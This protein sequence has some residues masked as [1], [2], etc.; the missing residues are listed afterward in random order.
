ME[1]FKKVLQTIKE[2]SLLQK[3]D[4]LLLG[5]SGGPDSVFLLHLL[6]QLRSQ[7]QLKIIVLHINHQLR[8]RASLRDEDFVK[9][10]ASDLNLPFL[11]KRIDVL[12]YQKKNKLSLEEAGRNLRH[13]VFAEVCRTQKIKKVVL[14]HTASDQVETILM[15][16]CRGTS[17]KGLSGMAY[18]Q[19]FKI[20]EGDKI[21]EFYVIRPLLDCF[22]E[23]ILADLKNRG[24]EYRIDQSN[25]HLNFTRNFFRHRIIP[26]FEKINP[27]FKTNLLR[28]AKEVALLKEVVKKELTRLICNAARYIEGRV[29]LNL[30]KWQKLN[31]FYRHE[32]I[33]FLIAKFFSTKD[34]SRVHLEEVVSLLEKGKVGR[35]KILPNNLAVYKDYDKIIISPLAL[36][37]RGP[38]KPS[39]LRIPGLTPIPELKASFRTKVVK[40]P[41]HTTTY[42][43]M[44]DKDKV[45][46]PLLIRSRRKGDYF[47]P[48]GGVGRKKL[49]DF[50]VDQK[51]SRILREEIPLLVDSNDQIV[52]VTGWR[53]DRRFMIDEKTK[54]ILLI[55]YHPQDYGEKQSL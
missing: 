11:A 47:Y 2:H 26:Y 21:T 20:E 7:F 4:R 12:A 13:Q 55:K 10:I 50:F 1:L 15:N 51:I 53:Q 48:C 28:Q 37:K 6:N 23:E 42:Q 43:I 5:V 46:L 16:L 30:L 41:S 36:L 33:W 54:N 49:Q 45:N 14:A 34:L 35:F 8:S 32:V 31:S 17:W 38:I 19:K 22:K 44:V 18:K 9:K 27:A 52:W 25:R 29:E 39:L 40:R 3:G 24:I